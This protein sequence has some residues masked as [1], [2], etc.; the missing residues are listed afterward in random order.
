MINE[1][2]KQ[3]TNVVKFFAQLISLNINT[4]GKFYLN[5]VEQQICIWPGNY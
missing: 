1:I 2:C 4:N 3:A 5:A